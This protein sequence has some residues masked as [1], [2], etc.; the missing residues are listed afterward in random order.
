MKTS[1][2][3]SGARGQPSSVL[4]SGSGELARLMRWPVTDADVAQAVTL[5]ASLSERELAQT[6]CAP[7]AHDPLRRLSTHLSADS[8]QRGRL[9]DALT[10]LGVARETGAPP[11]LVN[12][13]SLPV[14]VREL[15]HR[16]NSARARAFASAQQRR[17]DAYCQ[18]VRGAPDA[19]ALRRIG[20]F[21]PA[22]ALIEPGLTSANKGDWPFALTASNAGLERAARAIGDRISDFR[23]EAHA[24]TYGLEFSAVARS[25]EALGST[26]AASVSLSLGTN[27]P[28]VRPGLKLGLNGGIF[29]VTRTTNADTG[30]HLNLG[31]LELEHEG[32]RSTFGAHLGDVG[33]Y[34]TVDLE[35][36]TASAGLTADHL[37][38]AGLRVSVGLFAA[39]IPV[40]YF[41]DLFG[42]QPGL[43]GPMPELDCGTRYGELPPARRAWYARQGFDEATY[44][45]ALAAR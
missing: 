22:P 9:L 11:L 31:P 10:R 4:G 14:S 1:R 39:G 27:G 12:E 25:P 32:T 44:T 26:A 13:A 23:N 38:D 21:L 40:E 20:R 33:G 42:P 43:F 24:G 16:E 8:S 37:L 15:I 36:G 7:A 3:E 34:T 30:V 35:S 19:A 18:Q 6:L 45:S 29:S 2:V 17:L 5:L 28:V 41:A